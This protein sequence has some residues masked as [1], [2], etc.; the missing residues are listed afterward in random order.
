MV[1]IYLECID[2]YNARLS[3]TYAIVILAG[4]SNKGVAFQYTLYS[5]L[6]PRS[7]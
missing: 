4:P 6:R 2:L 1:N 3:V 5:D 7:K